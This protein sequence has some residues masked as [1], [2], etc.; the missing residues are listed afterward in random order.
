MVSPKDARRVLAFLWDVD[1]TIVDSRR[2]AFDATNE[3]LRRLNKRT[4]T[5]DEFRELF[6]SDYRVHIKHMG[7]N[8]ARE[9]SFLVDTWN[10]KLATDNGKF[11]LYDGILGVLR[12]LHGRSYK[13]AL[14][15]S[16]SR[17][18]IQQ[19]FKMFG[20]GQYFSA[21]IAR[22]DVDEQKPS[23]KPISQATERLSVSPGN[24]VLIDDMEDGI[25]AAK[26]LGATTIGVTWGFNTRRRIAS[27]EPDFIAKTPNELHR[28][29]SE[30][31]GC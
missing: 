10:A 11:K 31:L 18:Q 23:T 28:I 26:K 2:F 25:R 24:C 20:L 9:L 21:V 15:S 8:S 1:G 29:I 5:P 13:M 6:S 12:Y 27:A 22:E 19:Y 30:S 16:T 7:I 4:Y 17:S 14:V 3:A